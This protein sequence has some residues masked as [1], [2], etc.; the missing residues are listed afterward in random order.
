MSTKNFTP[1]TK[2]EKE[3]AKRQLRVTLSQLS[4]FFADRDLAQLQRITMTLFL[5]F[6]RDQ[7]HHLDVIEEETDFVQELLF[8]FEILSSCNIKALEFYNFKISA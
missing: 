8:L 4:S 2:A 1:K 5:A 3:E 7:Q 6:I